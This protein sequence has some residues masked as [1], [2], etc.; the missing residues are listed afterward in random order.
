MILS[1]WQASESLACLYFALTNDWHKEKW[2]DLFSARRLFRLIAKRHLSRL[3]PLRSSPSNARNEKAP[4][5]MTG[6]LLG[7][8]E[9]VMGIEPFPAPCCDPQSPALLAL[10][11][12]SYSIFPL[13]LAVS[14]TLFRHAVWTVFKPA[15][16]VWPLRCLG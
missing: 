1:F 16:S 3:K 7:C 11:L 15:S 14:S 13:S 10:Q 9:R 5:V 12:S 2:T 4:S 8:L 6:L